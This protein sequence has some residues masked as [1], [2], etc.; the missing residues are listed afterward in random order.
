MKA[1]AKPVP[2]SKPFINFFSI[3][4]PTLGPGVYPDTHS[5]RYNPLHHL[6]EAHLAI[7]RINSQFWDTSRGVFLIQ[8]NFSASRADK[9]AFQRWTIGTNR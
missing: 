1:T 7:K 4:F 3:L 8:L 5:K 6:N 2:K 9:Y